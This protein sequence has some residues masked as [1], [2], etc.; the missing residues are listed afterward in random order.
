MD[1]HFNTHRVAML[2]KL[3][4]ANEAKRYFLGFL[5]ILAAMMLINIYITVNSESAG[6]EFEAVMFSLIMPFCM[7]YSASII[8]KPHGNKPKCIDFMMTPASTLEKYAARCIIYIVGFFI[9]A[10][11]G[12]TLI[13]GVQY[14]TSVL[15]KH[16]V[17][18]SIFFTFRYMSFD[19]AENIAIL[20]VIASSYLVS[21]SLFTLGG[22][23]WPKHGI[24]IT[25]AY[26]IVM[27]LAINVFAQLAF[28]IVCQHVEIIRFRLLFDI[29]NEI[30]QEF[31]LFSIF[32]VNLA[33]TA[34][35]YTLAY[36]RLKEA[37]IVQ[38]W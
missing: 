18:E 34:F 9:V 38:R 36:F 5:I 24:W 3:Y 25:L 1:T 37:E 22:V 31:I 16:N 29:D 15:L 13:D 2:L 8:G 35:N 21:Q 20:L 27:T 14:F 17:N 28:Y 12:I 30:T 23:V 26:I 7:V 6:A 32:A 33:V 4:W 19:S 10:M 11:I